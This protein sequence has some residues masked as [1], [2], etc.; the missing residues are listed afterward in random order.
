M[1]ARRSLILAGGGVKVAFQAGVLQVW[2]DEAGLT[3]DHADGASGGT[4]NLAMWCQGMTGKEMADAWRRTKPVEGV[5]IN[6]M[7]FPR[8]FW[9]SSLFT[10]DAYRRNVF[11]TWGLDW[12][13][14]RAS[15]REASFNV[16]NF[17]KNEL[18]LWGADRMDEDRLCACVSLPMWFEPVVIE[19][20]TYID[21]VYVTDGNIEEA[22][23]RGADEVWVIWTVSM[24]GRWEDGFVAHYFQIIEAAANGQF[25]RI[26]RRIEE[27]NANIAAGRHAEFGR[28]I[29]LKILQAEV[30]IHYLINFSQDRLVECVNLGVEAARRWCGERGIQLRGGEPVSTDVHTVET[31]LEFTET[32]KG[33]VTPGETD[34]EKGYAQGKKDGNA[35]SFLLTIKVDGVNRFVTNPQ[36]EAGAV[37]WVECAEFGG[38]RTVGQ[39]VFNLFVDSGDPQ[40]KTMYYRLWIADDQNRPLTLLGFKDVRDDPGMDE[41]SDTTTLYVRILEGHRTPDEDGGAKVLAAGIFKLYLQDFM[42]QLTTFRVE[43]PTLA[44]RTAALARFG[45]LFMGKLW[46]VYAVQVLSSGPI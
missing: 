10:L 11:P 26:C 37:G 19:G 5:S 35:A 18:Q 30:P 21:P 23:R 8:L 34:Y 27:N 36:H 32:M 15:R 4:F 22:I 33:F 44:D 29:G 41:W 31:K 13:K 24:R 20:D 1:A 38:R 14:I 9:A 17:S 28:K 40:H 25:K 7:Q 39:G 46:D 16:Y 12:G 42:K 45:K 6:A 3:F 43:G 2:L